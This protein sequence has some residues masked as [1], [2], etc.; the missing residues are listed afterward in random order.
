MHGECPRA[1]R[2]R[3]CVE[4]KRHIGRQY[5]RRDT[6]GIDIMVSSRQVFFGVHLIRGRVVGARQ[7]FHDLIHWNAGPHGTYPCYAPQSL[8]KNEKQSIPNTDLL[9]EEKT[10]IHPVKRSVDS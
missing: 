10:E 6:V 1:R 8:Q 5:D 9:E 2:V 7:R 3:R 4:S